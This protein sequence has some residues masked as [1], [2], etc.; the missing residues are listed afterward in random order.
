MSYTYYPG[1]SLKGIGKV[2][3]ESLLAVFEALGHN[4]E[5]L[6]DW[7]CCGATTYMGIDQTQALALAARNLSLAENEKLKD[8]VAPCNACYFVLKRVD[9]YRARYPEL[10][11][12][13]LGVLREMGL[14]YQGKVRVRH[15]LDILHDDIGVDEIKKHVRRELNGARVACYYGCLYS[16]PY[17]TTE[18]WRFPTKMDDE[19]LRRLPDG[20]RRG[21]GHAPRLPAAARGEA[22]RRGHDRD[23]VQPLPVQPGGLPEGRRQA[24]RRGREDARALLHSAPGP[25][26]GPSVEEAGPPEAL[27]AAA[28]G[29]GTGIRRGR[30]GTEKRRS[31]DRG[32]RLPLRHQHRRQGERG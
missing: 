16:R 18:E 5:E 6:D 27:R 8:L 9:D 29:A 19:V 4:L 25:P 12:R 21:R 22:R 14:D 31:K 1:C 7:N 32:L 20:H 15:P 17:G 30:C 26:H 23:D 11:D 28:G 2:Y 10:M 13:V 3:E 24:L